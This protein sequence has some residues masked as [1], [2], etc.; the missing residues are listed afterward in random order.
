M[1]PK[2]VWHECLRYASYYAPRGRPR[3]AELGSLIG[4]RYLTP[5]DQLIGIIGEPGIGKSSVIR[6]MFPGLEL[7]NDDSQINVRP[8]PIIQMYREGNFRAFTF[9]ID[10]HF[11]S[12]FVNMYEIAEAIRA[13]LKQEKRIVVEHFDMLHPVLG[14]NAQCLIGIG[15]EI[16]VSRPNFFGPFPEDIKKKLEG[17]AIYRKMAHSAEDITSMILE[18]EFGFEH[19]QVHSDV[20]DG[21]VIELSRKWEKLDV[22]ALERR[23]KQVI[24]ADVPISYANENHIKIDAALYPCAGPRI[25]VS[26][27]AEI[28]N[29]R[30]LK[31]LVYDE[32]NDLFCL[33][34]IVGTRVAMQ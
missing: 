21:F 33:V 4:Q 24:D 11:E 34:G 3:L 14:I 13:A 10:A 1:K 16:I 26:R 17:T 7:T 9:H 28:Q 12:A 19:P 23:V 29:F 15:D 30:L 25:H 31:K 27:S 22:E 20:A 5:G 32:I 18:R 6:G 2:G 8:V